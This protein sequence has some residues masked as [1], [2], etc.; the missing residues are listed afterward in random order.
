[1]NLFL[2]VIA[3]G[4]K[5]FFKKHRVAREAFFFT[6]F[7]S[8]T[9]GCCIE[10]FSIPKCYYAYGDFTTGDKI[11][12]LENIN[13]YINTVFCMGVCSPF[14]TMSEY[15]EKSKDIQFSPKEVC[16]CVFTNLAHLHAKFWEDKTL[17]NEEWIANMHF[18]LGEK[19]EKFLEL[20]AEFHFQ[21]E[22]FKK[23]GM[24]STPVDQIFD[25]EL[26]E[27]LSASFKQTDWNA[28]KK[29]RNPDEKNW[30]QLHGDCHPG[31]F[32]IRTNLATQKIESKAVD[33]ECMTI[34]GAASELAL[35][36]ILGL[37]PSVRKSIEFDVLK[38]YYNLLIS[39]GVD[40]KRYT[41]DEC[42]YQ[43]VI[44]GFLR[45]CIY[46]PILSHMMDKKFMMV[47]GAKLLA[48]A[49]DHGITKENVIGPV[50]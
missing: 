37:D 50:F 48:F 5:E 7:G 30:T 32:F 14:N 41:Y 43:Y 46:I 45:Y 21:W 31:N 9:A 34:G 1:M 42:K 25:Q 16:L 12:I 24:E 40:E 33:F 28:Y 19:K 2:K 27:I 23:N 17:L 8:L 26:I 49:K 36:M 20:L 47:F 18:M 13:E 39:L 10:N 6:K 3:E 35:F 29:V 22:D 11:V 15:E 44:E 38:Q 4:K